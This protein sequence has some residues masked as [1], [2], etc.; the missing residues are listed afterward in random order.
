MLFFSFLPPQPLNKSPPPRYTPW[1]TCWHRTLTFKPLI[2]GPA[3][4]IVKSYY[5]STT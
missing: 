1:N 3:L 4:I 2:I 5:Q